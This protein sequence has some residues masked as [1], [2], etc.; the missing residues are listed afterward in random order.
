LSAGFTYTWDN[1]AQICD[2]VTDIALNATPVDPAASYRV[3]VNSFLADG[4]DLFTVLREGTDRLGG[5]ID[6]DALVD[7][8]AAH[9]PVALRRT[10]SPGSTRG[11]CTR[12]IHPEIAG[13]AALTRSTNRPR[14]A[15][16][17]DMALYWPA[18]VLTMLVLA[19]GFS[20]L[21]VATPIL[22][23]DRS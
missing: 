1:A 16:M 14:T 20:L 2:R 19:L 23:P 21:T 3:T 13:G 7:Y 17:T 6:L 22:E 12:A 11:I 4:G 5:S 10:G 15:R 8:F 18:G 9:S